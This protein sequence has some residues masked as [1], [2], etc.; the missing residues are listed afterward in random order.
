MA[1]QGLE[2]QN[3]AI[4]ELPVWFFEIQSAQHKIDEARDKIRL[5]RSRGEERDSW[6]RPGGGEP[7]P[8]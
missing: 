5:G 1:R 4:V 6:M 7:T 8:S 2:T 3:K